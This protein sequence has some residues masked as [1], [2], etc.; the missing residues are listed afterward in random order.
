MH[1]VKIDLPAT[2]LIEESVRQVPL[3][4]D[5]AGQVGLVVEPAESLRQ[6]TVGAAGRT[7]VRRDV[8]AA[9]AVFHHGGMLATSL[10]KGQTA[11]VE[12]VHFLR[13]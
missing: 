9:I 13:I 3:L 1:T 2:N 4:G 5:L 7:V 11:A 8:A 12:A 6:D 10:E